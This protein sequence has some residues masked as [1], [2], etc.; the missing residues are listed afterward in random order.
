MLISLVIY[1]FSNSK[2]LNIVFEDATT[3]ESQTAFK[4][5]RRFFFYIFISHLFLEILED[6]YLL[7]QNLHQKA[8]CY[9]K[10]YTP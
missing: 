2:P 7:H 4:K 10:I 8:F 5:K 6:A 1:K 3:I 9:T